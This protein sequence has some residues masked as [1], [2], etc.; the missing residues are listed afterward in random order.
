MLIYVIE[1]IQVF[2][3][4]NYFYNISIF[5]FLIVLYLYKINHYEIA[6]FTINI[7]HMLKYYQTG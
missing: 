7:K 6:M 3:P 4:S 2:N 5:Q 1:N